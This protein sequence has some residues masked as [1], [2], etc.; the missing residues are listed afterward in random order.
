[1]FDLIE[2]DDDLGLE[3]PFLTPPPAS[4]S[5]EAAASPSSSPVSSA[6]GAASPTSSSLNFG[7]LSV[8]RNSSTPYTDATQVRERR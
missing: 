8:D 5:S 1:M 6:G 7:S 2:T 3:L 4:A